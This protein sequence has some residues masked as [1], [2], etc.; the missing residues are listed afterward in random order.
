MNP[1]IVVVGLG[2]ADEAMITRA[3]FDAIAACPVRFVRTRRH[4]A[5]TVFDTIGGPAP[6]FLE[7]GRAHV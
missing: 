3:T 5:V 7:I 4:P 6:T 2:P 1:R